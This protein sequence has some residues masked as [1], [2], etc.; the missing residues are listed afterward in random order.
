[1]QSRNGKLKLCDAGKS[2]EG[3]SKVGCV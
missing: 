1:M 3:S 2:V